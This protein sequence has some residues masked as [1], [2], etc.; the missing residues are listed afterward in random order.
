MPSAHGDSDTQE[1]ELQRELQC[2]FQ[3]LKLG[4]WLELKVL[5]TSKP[6]LQVVPLTDFLG[7]EFSDPLGQK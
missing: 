4:L 7:D 5:L 3:E 2:E 1:L 6:F